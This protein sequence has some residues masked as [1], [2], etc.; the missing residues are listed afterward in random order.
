[1]SRSKR[2]AAAADAI[3]RQSSEVQNHLIDE[4]SYGKI[5]RRE[6]IRRGSLAGVSLTSLGILAAACSPEDTAVTTTAGSA[7]T[8]AAAPGTTAAGPTTTAAPA[9]PVTVRAAIPAPAVGIEPVLIN[10]EGGLTMFGQTGQYLVFSDAELNTV[11]VLAESWE[12][13]ATNDVWTFN[14]RQGVTYFDGTELKAADVVATFAGIAEGNA[15]SA[16]ETF[17]VDPANIVAVDDFTVEFTLAQPSGSFPFFV[18]SDNYN[19][20]ILPESFWQNYAEGE[21]PKVFAG[22]GPW[23][24]ESYEEGISAVYVKNENYWGDNSGQPD[25]LEVTFFANEAEAVIAFQDDR[26]DVIPH[27]SYSGGLALINDPNA[28][29]QSI[30]TAQH[31]QL[32]MDTSRPPFDD[33]RVRQAMALMLNRPTLVDGL[34]GGFG[35]AGNDHPIWQFYPMYNADA[36]PQRTEDLAMA[37]QLLNDAGYAD[38]FDAPLDTLEFFEIPDL[39]QLV[40]A[41]A[42]QLNN[43]NI[44]VRVTD[45]GTYYQDFWCGFPY[46]GPC[47]PGAI[48]SLGIVNYGHRGVPN[49]YMGAPL[50]TDG[51]WN[52]S[53]WSDPTYDDLFAQ[54][55]SAPD[56]DTQRQISGEIQ[57]LLNDE[58]PYIIPYFLDYI[59]VTKPNF[60]GLEVTGMGH[61]NLINSGFTD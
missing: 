35:V 1:M 11:P 4:Y 44:E 40:Q 53:H 28:D 33:K 36:V 51:I 38:G 20:A 19:A 34:L 29:T 3:R 54:F 26:V 24:N 59:S 21:Y 46:E 14:L 47:A 37:Q 13:N 41:S 55:T 61:T 52:A 9:G 7:A 10:D 30:S 22:T 50:V 31:R 8:T 15:G 6:F 18:S 12:P 32:Y 57:T 2:K 25:R 42:A 58:V 17:G 5:S 27:V 49:V 48:N 45:G 23:I 16:F 39:A 60:T 43:V 56:L